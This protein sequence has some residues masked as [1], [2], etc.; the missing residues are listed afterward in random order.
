MLK[1]S[2]FM[3][4]FVTVYAALPCRKFLCGMRRKVICGGHKCCVDKCG[5]GDAAEHR[6][7]GVYRKKVAKKFPD[8]QEVLS[9]ADFFR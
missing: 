4:F 9:A 1:L 5:G 7:S 2:V 6:S 8:W 3:G